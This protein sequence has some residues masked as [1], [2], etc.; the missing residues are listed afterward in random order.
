MADDR[1]R[2]ASHSLDEHERTNA[3]PGAGQGQGQSGNP[4]LRE[5][6]QLER[7]GVPEEGAVK[8][9]PPPRPVRSGNFH[10]GSVPPKPGQGEE[11]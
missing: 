8:P 6:R 7:Q 5:I 1:E 3:Q 4:F 9:G 11:Q 10:A 2:N